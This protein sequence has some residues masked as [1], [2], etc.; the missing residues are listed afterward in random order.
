[1]FARI[2][3]IYIVIFNFAASLSFSLSTVVATANNKNKMKSLEEYL[4]RIQLPEL[5]STNYKTDRET[6]SKVMDAQ[7]R[8]IPFENFDVVMGKSISMES[9]DVE[10]KLVENSRGGY[11]WEQNTLLKIALEAME[12]A[13]TPVL[14]RVRWGK[15]DDSAEPNTGFTHLALQ[16]QTDDGLFLADVGFAGTNS[17]E[18]VDLEVG[19]ESQ[20]L[21]EG[22]FR[23]VPSKHNDFQELELLIKGEWR[24]LYEWRPEPAPFV[25]QIACNWFSCTFPGAR[26]TT[27]FFCCRVVEGE[28][29]H[30]LNNEYVI[31]KGHGVEK[32]VVKETINEKTR[33]LDLMDQVF[34][35]KLQ[36]TEGIDRY[37]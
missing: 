19:K 2:C 16:V 17:M 11:C 29:H 33:L 25:D 22:Q 12:F 21:P 34:S 8:C 6:L 1:M 5:T 32:C 9:D 26:F 30:I 3:L 27:Q 4:K 13:V 18:P 20:T 14:C 7:S 37:L 31:R 10:T 24:P 28:R 35:I 36:H 15:P 23:V